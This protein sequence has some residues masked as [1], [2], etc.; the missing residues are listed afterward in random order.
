MMSE[1]KGKVLINL[2]NIFVL[3]FEW[4]ISRRSTSVNWD[5]SGDKMGNDWWNVGEV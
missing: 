1:R 5:G 2:E 3:G 4:K